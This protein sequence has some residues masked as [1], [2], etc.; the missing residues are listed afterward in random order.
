[1]WAIMQA[2]VDTPPP[3]VE[4]YLQVDDADES[5]RTWQ[6]RGVEMVTEPHDEPFGR[7]FALRDPDGRVLHVIQQL[8]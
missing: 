5:H 6:A 2:R 3:G 7:T 1:M 8:S 4:L